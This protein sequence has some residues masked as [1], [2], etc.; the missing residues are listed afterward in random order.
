MFISGVST[1]NVG[2]TLVGLTS[3]TETTVDRIE[4][5]IYVMSD[6]G[7]LIGETANVVNSTGV[8]VGNTVIGQIGQQPSLRGPNGEVTYTTDDGLSFTG[9][10][11]FSV[12]IGLLSDNSAIYPKVGDLRCIALQ[13]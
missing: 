3:A 10:K 2:D 5:T 12:K 6:T 11:S 9:Y 4:G 1:I 13:M 8:V 7:Y